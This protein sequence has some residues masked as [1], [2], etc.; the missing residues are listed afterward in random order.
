MGALFNKKDM[1]FEALAKLGKVQELDVDYL[2][3][4]EK[5]KDVKL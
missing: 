1:D 5:N 4:Y 3:N 2:F